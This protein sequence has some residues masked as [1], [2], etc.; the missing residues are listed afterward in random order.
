MGSNR[1]IVPASHWAVATPPTK[2]RDSYGLTDSTRRSA[3][4][5]GTA[6]DQELEYD[7]FGCLQSGL[8]VLTDSGGTLVAVARRHTG[9]IGRSRKTRDPRDTI[10][11]GPGP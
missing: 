4:A 1:R 6:T 5:P 7:V 9:A 11:S 2:P 8:N 3:S 10:A